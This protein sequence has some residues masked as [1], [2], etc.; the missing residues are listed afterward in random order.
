MIIDFHTH[1]Y[2]RKVVEHVIDTLTSRSVIDIT[3]ASDGTLFGLKDAMQRDG[4]DLSVVLPVAS[5]PDQVDSINELNVKSLKDSAETKVT[6]FAAIHPHTEKVPEVL[7]RIKNSGF[8][9]IKLHPYNQGVQADDISYI[10]LLYEAESLGLYTVIHAGRDLSFPGKY[11][12]T[13]PQLK[14]LVDEVHPEHFI[15]AHMGGCYDW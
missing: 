6:F 5:R 11:V 8:K 10:R 7:K 9:G 1:T 2:P 15:L 13:P 14:K 4:V 3:L 12:S